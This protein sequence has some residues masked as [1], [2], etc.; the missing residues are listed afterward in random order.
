[1]KNEVNDFKFPL[2]PDLVSGEGVLL[3]GYFS[4]QQV[5]DC[6]RSPAFP[7]ADQSFSVSNLSYPLGVDTQ[8]TKETVKGK[9][10]YFKATKGKEDT[11]EKIGLYMVDPCGTMPICIVE[12]GTIYG[13]GEKGF[14]YVSEKQGYGYF[15]S[16]FDTY[17][18]GDTVT[19][20]PVKMQI[21]KYSELCA[22]F[23][24]RLPNITALFA[25]KFPGINL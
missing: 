4:E 3:I 23:W 16:L 2:V 14:L 13:C 6:Q 15:V 19:W 12:S 22:T 24:F 21:C 17:S 9:L 10:F 20:K 8:I 5:F 7:I 18:S 1:M 25:A 11:I